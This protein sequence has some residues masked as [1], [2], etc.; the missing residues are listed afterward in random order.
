ML[1]FAWWQ[2]RTACDFGAVGQRLG[3]KSSQHR[4]CRQ[5][6]NVT[7]TNSVLYIDNTCVSAICARCS[8]G[9]VVAWLREILVNARS[10]PAGFI[11]YTSRARLSLSLSRQPQPQPQIKSPSLLLQWHAGRSGCLPLLCV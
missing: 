1:S 3:Q 10:N 9:L 6:L 4:F 2:Q 11:Q 5:S 7:L 8:N